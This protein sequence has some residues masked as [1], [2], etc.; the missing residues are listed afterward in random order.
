MNH[1]IEHVL[2]NNDLGEHGSRMIL[3]FSLLSKYCLL[4]T[5]EAAKIGR[6]N[7]I[8]EPMELKAFCNFR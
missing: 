5:I 2:Y 8:S 4:S 1:L 3:H 6:H 7:V